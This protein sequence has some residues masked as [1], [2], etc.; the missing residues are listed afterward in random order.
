MLNVRKEIIK[1]LFSFLLT[2][3]DF[4]CSFT[5]IVIFVGVLLHPQH[6]LSLLSHFLLEMHFQIVQSS[7]IEVGIG[8]F[9]YRIS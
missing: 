8:F 9:F 5:I 7:Y 2:F 4:S 1:L 6:H 3:M